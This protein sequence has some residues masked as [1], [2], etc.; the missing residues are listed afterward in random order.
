MPCLLPTRRPFRSK[1]ENG[2]QPRC[3]LLGIAPGGVCQAVP[4]PIHRWSL[5]PPFHPYPGTR[6]QDGIFSVALSVVLTRTHVKTPSVRSGGTL[7][8]G[9]RTFLPGENHRSDCP[10]RSLFQIAI[11]FYSFNAGCLDGSCNRITEYCY[12]LLLKDKPKC[13]RNLRIQ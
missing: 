1:P 3:L 10:I 2:G 6:C 4:L 5:T 8:C 13:N 11:V 7:S 12:R 9:V